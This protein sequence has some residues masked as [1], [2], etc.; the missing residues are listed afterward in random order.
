MA[1]E[2]K[3]KYSAVTAITLDFTPSGAGLANDTGRQTAVID[4]STMRYER[5]ELEVSVQ[6]GT[7]PTAHSVFEIYC[8][9]ADDEGTRHF[10]DGAAATEGVLTPLNSQFVGMLRA[11]SAGTTDQILKGTFMI[12]EPGPYWGIIVYNRTGVA[13]KNSDTNDWL[14]YVGINPEIQ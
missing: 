6:L 8:F 11:D 7:S 9:R 13:L 2:I 4:N 14:R 3:R 12:D 1:T 5:I 10:D